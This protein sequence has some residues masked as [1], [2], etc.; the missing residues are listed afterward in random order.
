M[1]AHLEVHELR[2]R[3]CLQRCMGRAFGSHSNI[4]HAPSE[5]YRHYLS[6]LASYSASVRGGSSRFLWAAFVL[7]FPCSTLF[8]HEV[9]SHGI[10][11]ALANMMVWPALIAYETCSQLLCIFGILSRKIIRKMTTCKL[12]ATVGV[13]ASASH[14]LSRSHLNSSSREDYHQVEHMGFMPMSNQLGTVKIW[15]FQYPPSHRVSQPQ[16]FSMVHEVCSRG[17]WGG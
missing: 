15:G 6:K 4:I 3:L 1:V 13:W 16:F 5:M 7:G 2:Y 12:F 9:C 10:P 17:V 11:N 8:S 14:V